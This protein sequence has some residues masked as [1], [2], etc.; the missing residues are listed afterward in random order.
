MVDSVVDRIVVVAVVVAVVVDIVQAAVRCS[1]EV[2]E[3]RKGEAYDRGLLC[4]ERSCWMYL[5]C[6]CCC[7]VQLAGVAAVHYMAQPVGMAVVDIVEV[8]VD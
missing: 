6:C 4:L 1:V 8:S 3:A 7:C 5:L 2:E